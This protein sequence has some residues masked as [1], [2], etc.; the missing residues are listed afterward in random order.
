M[1]WRELKRLAHTLKSS[2]D[3]IGAREGVSAAALLER[4]ADQHDAELARPALADLEAKVALL[5]PAVSQLTCEPQPA[6][7]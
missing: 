3:N 1:P 2:A 4:L 6:V 5:L 7:E